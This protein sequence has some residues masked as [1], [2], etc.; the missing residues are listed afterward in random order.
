MTEFDKKTDKQTFSAA[1]DTLDT[2][3]L[4]AQHIVGVVLF[5]SVVWLFSSDFAEFLA[6]VIGALLLLQQIRASNRRA[7][8][9]EDTAKA[10]QQT[11]ASTEKGNIAE[12]F[13]NAVEHLGHKSVS[14]RLGGV[15]ALHHLA[16]E[17]ENYRERVFEI[18]CAHIRQTTTDENYTPRPP[19]DYSRNVTPTIEIASIL[20]LLFTSKDRM[21][22]EDLSAN[23]QYANLEGATLNDSE[24]QGADL[25]CVN[26]QDASLIDAKLNNAYLGGAN[27]ANAY[28]REIDMTGAVLLFAVA[29]DVDFD[30]ANLRNVDF[31]LADCRDSSFT[32]ARNLKAEQFK[33][34]CYLHGAK[35]SAKLKKEIQSKYPGALDSQPPK[36]D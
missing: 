21:V 12:R 15:Y 23:L 27:M 32:T 3:E 25:E 34:G 33:P 6:Y 7:T 28:V 9:A 31:N 26:L 17:E 5:L 24:L 10:M 13:K 14:V 36:D 8:A 11:A 22:Y 35:F 2:M 30:K 18:L 4:K 16:Q 20:T 1:M 29:S 19:T